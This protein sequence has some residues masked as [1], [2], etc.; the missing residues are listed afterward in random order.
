M[1]ERIRHRCEKTSLCT[2]V[3]LDTGCQDT[4]ETMAMRAYL[5]FRY[6]AL[7]ASLQAPEV[8]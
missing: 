3:H 1:S 6:E 2:P 4:I 7:C 8:R 5:F